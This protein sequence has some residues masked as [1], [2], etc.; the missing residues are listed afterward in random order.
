MFTKMDNILYYIL[1][2]Y[3]R[4][5]KKLMLCLLI[6]KVSAGINVLNSGGY[7]TQHRFSSVLA[8]LWMLYMVKPSIKF[9]NSPAVPTRSHHEFWMK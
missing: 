2:P 1:W 7:R 6:L 9:K 8:A 5:K 3:E 4:R